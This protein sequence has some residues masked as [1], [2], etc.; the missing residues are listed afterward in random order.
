MFHRDP[1]VARSQGRE[2]YINS[3][4][5]T[6]PRP[7]L[8]ARNVL[9]PETVESLF[10]AYRLTGDPI[11]RQWVRLVLLT[12]GLELMVRGQG[13]EIFQ[14]FDKHCRLPD[15]GFASIYDVDQVPVEHEDRMETFWVVSPPLSPPPSLSLI[16]MVLG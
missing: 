11:Y 12:R 8:D 3:R 16:S 7:P 2:W 10:I 9:R 15:G 6:Y 4:K 14:A 5:A 1:K 13:W